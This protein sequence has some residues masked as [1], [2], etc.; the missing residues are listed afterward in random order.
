M[1]TVYYVEACSG[2]HSGNCIL[3]AGYTRKEAIKSAYGEGG[4]LPKHAWISEK[5]MIVSEADEFIMRHG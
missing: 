4:K 1:I 2:V 5:K 3:G